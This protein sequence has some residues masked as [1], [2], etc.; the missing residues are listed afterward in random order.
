MG[1]CLSGGRRR[2]CGL[3][4]IVAVLVLAALTVIMAVADAGDPVGQ[5]QIPIFARELVARLLHCAPEELVLQPSDAAG[6][7]RVRSFK[8]T[9]GTDTFAVT[10]EEALGSVSV[11]R[12]GADTAPAKEIGLPAATEA[13]TRLF[14]E[15]V[16]N[17]GDHMRLIEQK[18]VPMGTY[19]FVWRQEP[20]PQVTT[21]DITT[22]ML[23][24]DGSLASIGNRHV[25]QKP[26]VRRLRVDRAQAE[27]LG[28]KIALGRAEKGAQLTL[29][30]SLLVL[31]SAVKA[32][33]GPVWQLSYRQNDGRSLPGLL[34]LIDAVKGSEVKPVWTAPTGAR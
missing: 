17:A 29:R 8:V 23:N 18:R 16:P 19:L 14:K 13:A 10:V 24:E 25:A 30:E 1:Y 11:L 28:L 31:S 22:L 6:S 7:G 15:V 9:R 2:L 33:Q 34:V 26:D 4:V 32:D 3:L 12:R 21:G 20:E 5:Y 27:E